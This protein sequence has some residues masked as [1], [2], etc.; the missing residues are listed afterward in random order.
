MITEIFSTVLIIRLVASFLCSAA[1]GVVFKVAPRHLV[2][3]GIS[4]VIVYFV[5]HL[6]A[7]F[8]G[9]LFVAAF[10]STVAGAVYAE[11]YARLRRTP[12]TV[13]L[14]AAIIPIVPGG[15]LYYTMQHALIGDGEGALKYFTQTMSIALGIAGGIVVS[16]LVFKMLFEKMAERKKRRAKR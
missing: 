7:G 10:L 5:Y 11:F 16:A 2:S 3:A 8:G 15:D 12:V 6:V 1:F 4:G 14:Y 13:M 9:S